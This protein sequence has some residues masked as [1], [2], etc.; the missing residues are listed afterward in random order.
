MTCPSHPGLIQPK[1][2][3]RRTATVSLHRLLSELL[4]GTL[5]SNSVRVSLSRYRDITADGLL[6]AASFKGLTKE[7]SRS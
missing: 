1:M 6:R 4:G 5:L 2:G 3:I 7:A